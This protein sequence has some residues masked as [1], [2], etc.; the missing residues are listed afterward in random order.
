MPFSAKAATTDSSSFSKSI[1]GALKS[2]H[3]VRDA[4]RKALASFSLMPNSVMIDPAMRDV[5][6]LTLSLPERDEHRESEGA[7]DSAP[8]P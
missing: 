4:W 5:A 3:V 7:G 1:L 8:L 2:S 6:L